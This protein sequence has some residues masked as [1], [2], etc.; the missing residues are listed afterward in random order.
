MIAIPTGSCGR[1]LINNNYA[2]DGERIL[3]FVRWL[4]EAKLHM[5][6]GVVRSIIAQ[7]LLFPPCYNIMTVLH[8]IIILHAF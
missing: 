3:E 8:L 4:S 2:L 7:P 5:V 1:Q 6:H